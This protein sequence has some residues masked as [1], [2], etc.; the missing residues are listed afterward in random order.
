MVRALT[1]AMAAEII[2]PGVRP[3]LLVELDF[4]GGPLRLTTRSRDLSF[5]GQ[6]YGGDGV[7]LAVSNVEETTEI[8]PAG[9]TLTLAATAAVR[10]IM[11]TAFFQ[12]RRAR[13]WL[14]FVDAA[15]GVISAPIPL[16]GGTMDAVD[17]DDDPAAPVVRL[18]IVTRL[19]D[20]TIARERRWSSEDQKAVFPG[21]TGLRY[22]EAIQ[23]YEI[24]SGEL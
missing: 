14:G 7:L 19:R 2:K 18:D 22:V 8:N 3:F 17:Y 4:A 12:G 15:D 13:L 24:R 10:A 6:V 20:L 11:T 23:D 1:A 9:L 21:D 5:N 16:A